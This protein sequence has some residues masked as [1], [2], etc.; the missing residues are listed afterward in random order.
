M[1]GPLEG[2]IAVRL[3]VSGGTVRVAHIVVHRPTDVAAALRGKSVSDALRLMPLLFSVCGVAQGIAALSACEAALGLEPAPAHRT[4]RRLL[5]LAETLANHAWNVFMDGPHRLGE[6][7]DTRHLATLRAVTA[8]IL[9]ALYPARDHLRPGGGTLQP[10]RESL[11]V[12]AARLD[13]HVAQTVLGGV[14]FPAEI[15]GLAAWAA[16]GMT[17]AARLLRRALDAPGFGACAVEPL[18]DRPA[19]WFA[20]RLAADPGFG[21]RPH[22]DGAPAYTGPLARMVA[23]PPV[24]E[25]LER[26]GP[27]LA[28]HAAARLAEL[29]ELPVRMAEL[30]EELPPAGPGV[31]RTA[32]GEGA[33]VVETAR[34]RLAHWVRLEQGRIADYRTVAPTE[35]NFHPDGP[36][37]RGL[38]GAPAD[39]GLPERAGLLVAA[40]DPCVAFGI[41]IEREG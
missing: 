28:A 6:P 17:P 1:S 36:L 22:D 26:F 8:G 12:A 40:L 19:E 18:A 38:S 41:D 7:P 39:A 10:N 9:P 37:A 4:A 32:P 35:W 31:E 11:A 16:Q 5:V 29:A 14:P 15:D 3:T 33:G 20:R 25:I 27:G 24:V 21:A 30:A 13:A 2:S 34:G 23:R